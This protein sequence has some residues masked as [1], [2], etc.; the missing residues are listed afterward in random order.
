MD[1]TLWVPVRDLLDT[2]L[3]ESV[4][5]GWLGLKVWLKV[6]VEVGEKVR[7]GVLEYD[8]VT[9]WDRVRVGERDTEVSDNEVVPLGGVTEREPD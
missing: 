1:D 4:W 7:V 2:V 3:D 9:L 8:L 5:E 6:E